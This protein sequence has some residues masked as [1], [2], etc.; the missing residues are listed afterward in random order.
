[1]NAELENR[2]TLWKARVYLSGSIENAKDGRSWREKAKA[3]LNKIG[4]VCFDPYEKPFLHS[5]KEDEKTRA[6]LSA[7][8][9]SGELDWVHRRMKDIRNEDLR[10]CDISDFGLFMVSQKIASWGTAEELS[11]MNSQKKACFVVVEGGKK[12]IPLW[13]LGM[14][15][16]HYFY[17][18]LEDALQMIEKIDA[19][20]RDIDSSRWRL[21]KPEYR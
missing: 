18:S 1:M 2:G 10:L 5:F 6:E 14:L 19:G 20:K 17:N 16:P 3:R 7:A 11:M 12:R 21:L 13:L 15:P 9:K 4:I 8:M